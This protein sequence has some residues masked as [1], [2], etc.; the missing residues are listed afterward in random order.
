MLYAGI[1]WTA[2][3]Y[4]VEVIDDTGNR[5]RPAARWGAE[6]VPELT[7]WLSAMG[8]A[9]GQPC[10]IVVESTNGLVDGLLTAGGLDVHRADPWILPPRPAFGSVPA[11]TLAEQART[12]LATLSPLTAAGGG[13][14]GR[15][16]DYHGGIQRSAPIE[17]E[18]TRSGRF[19]RHGSR[20][21]KEV[22]LTFDDGP[23]PV[24]TR[25]VLEILDR[26]Q[27]RATFFCVGLHINALPDEVRRI[28][29]AGHSL[30]NHTWSHPFLPD[31]TSSQFRLQIERTSEAFEKAVGEVPT[32]F[33]PPYGARTPDALGELISDGPAVA[34]WDVDSWDWARPGPEKIAQTVLDHT[35]PGSMILMHD[36]G[37]DRRESVAALPKVIEGLLE[38]DLRCVSVQDLLRRAQP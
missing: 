14:T 32:F 35:Q 3:G 7:E 30:G 15:D 20:D 24:F 38:R 18:L 22:A 28:T 10:A 17:A 12:D 33:R 19:F 8:G 6:R 23:D 34:L 25:Q 5:T 29:D 4:V 11:I 2:D 37:G 1:A 36:G 13:Q 26:Y 16:E 31:L 21:R 9:S 27:V